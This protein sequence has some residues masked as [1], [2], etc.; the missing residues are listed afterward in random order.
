M[1]GG[2]A[3]I[4]GSQ[5]I[6]A[7]LTIGA[8]VTASP[9]IVELT[10][11]TLLNN[12]TLI[13]SVLAL[14]SGGTVANAGTIAFGGASAG[15][16]GS[17][18][19]SGVV[20]NNGL[21]SF[22][23][24]GN[25]NNLFTLDN[26]GTI[27]AAGNASITDGAAGSQFSNGGT[28]TLSGNA[29]IAYAQIRNAGTLHIGG[30]AGYVN[31]TG[32]AGAVTNA[33][34]I[35]FDGNGGISGQAVTNSGTVVFGGSGNVSTS[36]PVTNTGTILFKAGGGSGGPLLTNKGSIGLDGTTSLAGLKL[37]NSGTIGPVNGIATPVTR[38]SYGSMLNTGLI[39]LNGTGSTVYGG[40][41][42][43]VGTMAVH[44]EINVSSI[45]NWGL[46]A[47]WAGNHGA[48]HGTSLQ[49]EGTVA[50]SAGT[51]EIIQS[52][53]LAND[54]S[55]IINGSSAALHANTLTNSYGAD[56]EVNAYAITL[57][58]NT[59][60]Q[61]V[62][63]NFG[64]IRLA[65]A[66]GL[67]S[68]S[69]A[70]FDVVS[71]FN[72]GSIFVGN[73]IAL[74]NITPS[75]VAS[76][77]TLSNIGT[78]QIA[79]GSNAYLGGIQ[80]SN[81]GLIQ[82]SATSGQALLVDDTPTNNAAGTLDYTSQLTNSGTIRFNAGKTGLFATTLLNTGTIAFTADS[83]TLERPP[84]GGSIL[85]TNATGAL[86]DFAALNGTGTASIGT[87]LVNDGVL[88]VEA[89]ETLT[90]SHGV[91]GRGQIALVAGATLD[92]AAGATI[93]ATEAIAVRGH[94]ATISIDA[95]VGS[96]AAM[97]GQVINFGV[98]DVLDFRNVSAIGQGFYAD[99]AL[100]NSL[101]SVISNNQSVTL[102]LQGDYGTAHFV[103]WSDGHGGTDVA[104]LA[105]DDV[106]IGGNGAW[107]TASGWSLG[108][109]PSGVQNA[110]ISGAQTVTSTTADVSSSGHV[111]LFLAGGTLNAQ[112]GF[113]GLGLV[114]GGAGL[115]DA[116]D[117]VTLSGAANNF[118]TTLVHAQNAAF[119]AGFLTNTGTL[120][121]TSTTD[122]GSAGLY[123]DF[124]ASSGIYN[125]GTLTVAAVGNDNISVGRMYNAERGVVSV[126]S[127]KSYANLWEDF[128]TDTTLENRGQIT[129]T[130][131]GANLNA[132]HVLNT[133]TLL[134]TATAANYSASLYVD[135]SNFGP[136]TTQ[137]D[138]ATS[139]DHLQNDGTI[140][141]TGDYAY[142]N[143]TDLT[144]TGTLILV[145][146]QGAMLA[147][148]ITGLAPDGSSTYA[149]R[150][151]NSGAVSVTGKD[152]ALYT[153]SFSNAGTVTLTGATAEFTAWV[154][155]NGFWAEND[156]ANAVNHAGARMVFAGQGRAG[157]GSLY[158]ALTNDGVLAVQSGETLTV[159]NTIAGSGT[160]QVDAGAD[161]TLLDP[162]ATSQ[163]IALAAG[164]VV[165][166][167]PQ[168][169]TGET[170]TGLAAGG[171][172]DL[173]GADPA[174]ITY[175][176]GVLSDLGYGAS[177]PGS[178]TLAGL[179]GTTMVTSS[180]GNGGTF[181]TFAPA[182]PV[183][184]GVTSPVVSI[185]GAAGPF[186]SATVTDATGQTDTATITID[187]PSHGLL[188]HL[189]GG[190]Y[191]QT[192][193]VYRLTGTA[194]DITAA[195]HGLVYVPTKNA[196]AATEI[197]TTLSLAVTN[198]NGAATAATTIATTLPAAR[199]TP[200]T[201]VLYAGDIFAS[202]IDAAALGT[203]HVEL[204]GHG[205]TNLASLVTG[206]TELEISAGSDLTLMGASTLSNGQT[207]SGAGTLT[208][209]GSL[210]ANDP[211]AQT[212]INVAT[213]ILDGTAA[214]G[215]GDPLTITSAVTTDSAGMFTLQGHGDLILGGA[216]SRGITVNFADATGTLELDAPGSFAG[217]ITGFV[218]GDVLYLRHADQYGMRLLDGVLS[219]VPASGPALSIAMPGIA[220]D[221]HA[222]FTT[223]Y[224]DGVFVT[225]YPGTVQWTGG[226]GAW[227]DATHW[228]AGEAPNYFQ[229]AQI[230][231]ASTVTMA[232]SDASTSSHVTA[233]IG[234]AATLRAT[235][236]L[237]L[238]TLTNQ[239]S[240]TV[241]AGTG[242]NRSATLIAN[243]V[244][245]DHGALSIIAT[246]GEAALDYTGPGITRLT[247]TGSVLVSGTGAF[248]AMEEVNN[249]GG[250]IVLDGGADSANMSAI[251][252]GGAVIDGVY[253][254]PPDSEVQNFGSLTLIGRNAALNT[255]FLQNDGTLSVTGTG[256][257]SLAVID[258]E[259]PSV[260]PDGRPADLGM[261]S[262]GGEIILN[263]HQA[264]LY[265][266][267]LTNNGTIRAT[268]DFFALGV[269]V[270]GPAVQTDPTKAV[271]T[272][273]AALITLNARSGSGQAVIETALTNNGHLVIGQGETAEMQGEIA[274]TGTILLQG[275]GARAVFDDKVAASQFVGLDGPG[276][277]LALGANAHVSA[278]ILGFTVGDVLDFTALAA[279]TTSFAGNVLSAMAGGVTQSVTLAGDYSQDIL[280]TKA[281]GFGGTLVSLLPAVDR[282]I[283][284]AGGAWGDVRN[285]STG[286]A[287]TATQ[288]AVI[289]VAGAVVQS[290]TG[291]A[292][293]SPAV[294]L[295]ITGATLQTEGRLAL[296]S[297]VDRG[298]VSIS[299]SLGAV[300]S[301]GALSNSGSFSA[302]SDIGAFIDINGAT[303]H[304]SAAA[305]FV[306]NTG[307]G[308]ANLF[309]GGLDNAG[310]F[311]LHAD[312]GS[313]Y[314]ALADGGDGR[315]ANSGSMSLTGNSV[316][317]YAHGVAN[318]GSISIDGQGNQVFFS[319]GGGTHADSFRNDGMMTVTGSSTTVYALDLN[320]TGTLA[321]TGTAGV[322]LG[323][324][325]TAVDADGTTTL[326][327][328]TNT[329][330]L[331]LTGPSAA[332]FT[333]GLDNSGSII[334]AGHG[335]SVYAGNTP[336][337]TDIRN[338]RS[339]VIGFTATSQGATFNVGAPLGNDGL[340]QDGAGVTLQLDGSIT[341]AGIVA[342]ADGATLWVQGVASSQTIRLGSNDT[343]RLYSPALF[344]GQVTGFAPGDIIDVSG[345]NET[346][347]LAGGT[348]SLT[349]SAGT[350]DT[351]F[352]FSG[353][354]TGYRF[355]TSN[356]G[357][358]GT[359]ITLAPTLPSL[360]YTP[361]PLTSTG[362][363]VAPFATASITDTNLAQTDTATII[364]T[365]P[366]SGLLTHLGG[367][368][369]NQQSGVYTVTGTPAAVTAAIDG[370]LFLPSQTTEPG[371]TVTTQFTLTDDNPA[372]NAGS[373]SST[374]ATTLPLV[375]ATP[376]KLSIDAT[377]HF[378]GT[379][380]A[381]ALGVTTI[382][383][384]GG[385][386]G[387]EATLSGLGSSITG[388]TAI[389]L[390]GG[391]DWT[392]SGDNALGDN[393]TISGSGTLNVPGTLTA[394]VQG[395]LSV[396]TLTHLN[397]TGKLIVCN[398]DPLVVNG[399]I[400][401]PAG[402]FGEADI[403]GHGE[404]D[405]NGAVANE[406]VV[407]TDNT[408]TLVLGDVA[409][410]QGLITGF[411]T[412]TTL[413]LNATAPGPLSA[414]QHNGTLTVTDRHGA[415][416]AALALTEALQP[417]GLGLYYTATQNNAGQIT[418][419]AQDVPISVNPQQSFSQPYGQSVTLADGINLLTGLTGGA[420]IT[421]GLGSNT[422]DIAG[423]ANSITER[424]TA[425]ASGQLSNN[426]ITGLQGASRI[427]L[428]RGDDRIEIGG[429]G[430]QITLGDGN[431]QVRV[432]G[433]GTSLH[434]G[435][436]TSRVALSGYGNVVVT[437]VQTGTTIDA[438]DGNAAVRIDG[439]SAAVTA[440]GWGDRFTFGDGVYEL[441]GF[442]GNATVQ[443]NW[444]VTGSTL[445]LT[446]IAPDEFI[447]DGGR[448][449][450]DLPGG[451]LYATL[452]TASGAALAAA[453]DGHGGTLITLASST[454]APTPA[455]IIP[456]IPVAPPLP[457][458]PAEATAITLPDWNQHF[459]GLDAQ[460]YE[461]TSLI[462]T[463]SIMLGDGNNT[464]SAA[465]WHN[466]IQLGAG[467]N[468]VLAGQGDAVVTIMG[469]GIN[470]I[471]ADGWHNHIA[472]ANGRDTIVAGQGDA[473]VTLGAGTDAVILAG[474]HNLVSGGAGAAVIAGG[475]ANTY[476]VTGIGTAGGLDIY[477]FG[478]D[479]GNVLDLSP[480]LGAW[481]G[482]TAALGGFVDVRHGGAYAVVSVDRLGGGHFSQVALLGHA[483][484]GG[485]LA[486]VHSGALRV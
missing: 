99:P 386:V 479:H 322:G 200:Q 383:L 418:I 105:P 465:G 278:T 339:G 415:T 422:I 186:L 258:T 334:L 482:N 293:T 250:T 378:T 270:P 348:L 159:Y 286:A 229:T 483:G 404:L 397:L 456:I 81:T 484:A 436:G 350:L 311:V 450:G 328:M 461:V 413:V 189:S 88:Q 432:T 141:L 360:A 242:D 374:I 216:V 158:S 284:R 367:G 100:N 6:P 441:G 467:N 183:I 485:M 247:N 32:T 60:A 144:N 55:L 373:V 308:P 301:L 272:T 225:L 208:V 424:D 294:S 235:T 180:D 442:D 460:D 210:K 16:F 228:S 305:S 315:I 314:A 214:I 433:G 343:L 326:F 45:L 127:T 338:S 50:L 265:T 40:L 358:G 426:F 329:G 266:H 239:G 139:G 363:A 237:E 476:Q 47:M 34:L 131:A 306:I 66:A 365:N 145:G 223:D 292:F 125:A 143:D 137:A 451:G 277:S 170:I 452:T 391:S 428:G 196:P 416:L 333:N 169:M 402:S 427:D 63:S 93:G 262:N 359:A 412:G 261:I 321:L 297:L 150:F 245:N 276:Q 221:D 231:T 340:I 155:G 69:S 17:D 408:G 135:V 73:D 61:S 30:A 120:A 380:D 419:T 108:A 251:G 486:L 457:T 462:G 213:L 260:S 405:L 203:P 11:A 43:N 54:G 351:A 140:I 162:I 304:N 429:Y 435:A 407:F 103:S 389:T 21:I 241:A 87:D 289:D 79:G 335:G 206:F 331:S 75:N 58:A 323:T 116:G 227:S 423:Y 401:A 234:T 463:A 478:T 368:S 459:T 95:S 156:P 279:A 347:S 121:V 94:G 381:K 233:A 309:A 122:T 161:L 411:G 74:M 4:T 268:A 52:G 439:G 97:A 447:Q 2:I 387:Q 319:N 444:S 312:S 414:T 3:L 253:H 198:T 37:I 133:G 474:F 72:Y 92:L 307:T 10:S 302:A 24:A 345:T 226:D 201:L 438:G 352:A 222:V 68:H 403:Q 470:A 468:I 395:A 370:L 25:L 86:I 303:I 399:S 85:A 192:T 33:G 246:T 264:G 469:N 98:G 111:Q 336:G 129:L 219:L 238:A 78:L 190:S 204:T 175:L 82:L 295:T 168:G 236:L 107:S 364:V 480:V 454:P 165:T 230:N 119:S 390:A 269:D 57:T 27:T 316:A 275:Q 112:G 42:D 257:Q 325:L 44:D 349:N 445:D 224:G 46:L 394:G 320:N 382:E 38:L 182:R 22:V 185:G 243:T 114:T 207:L 77:A 20:A 318:T 410:F 104:M 357:D 41:L 8:A 375:P 298:V 466:Q 346:V 254:A 361:T 244:T 430:S 431:D 296:A 313:A 356:D 154:G 344:H 291:D 393:Q 342:L 215:S 166:L 193:G 299:G 400:S 7:V 151:V 332:L 232:A 371:R 252:G 421:V 160:I 171:T 148:D 220:P 197:D 455:P 434:L 80:I 153:F 195:L 23:A 176:N 136:N 472:V 398:N 138:H 164:G 409:A 290:G 256:D 372:G 205:N 446:D 51:A 267:R 406:T 172:I 12:G 106:W 128:A 249:L 255:V 280:T 177:A 157:Q 362:G 354:L 29:T 355:V 317:L 13:P 271:N 327:R 163:T 392:L 288:S 35:S 101:L 118:A 173:R 384:T 281:D 283:G 310:R 440:G 453:S 458:A 471:Q 449:V 287:P 96:T 67:A 70:E 39:W 109:V 285:W 56:I 209:A 91:T 376:P 273:I 341:G 188:T 124:G 84:S 134:I 62:A 282:W 377:D 76:S 475:A 324:A 477:D 385:T 437:G 123:A 337:F 64:T 396:L 202:P 31:V 49:N 191:N 473:V 420:A 115:L 218:P 147:T 28:V 48:I 167:Y 212:T 65:L 19:L 425:R 5:A 274:G 71:L 15:L 448:L 379:I 464:V 53:T 211:A 36:G 184:S 248:V 14:R 152:A 149:G 263:G 388:F 142:S 1:P 178:V 259:W 83:A 9:N 217:A 102:R 89:G 18:G 179:S 130:G 117:R 132:T 353:A 330:S 90:L 174:S 300:A 194:A 126:S 481:N 110:V 417:A 26:E 187:A 369:Y 181:I 113:T 59:S 443:L 366:A 146:T 199:G 240:V